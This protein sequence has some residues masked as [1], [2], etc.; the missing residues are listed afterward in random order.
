MLICLI[1]VGFVSVGSIMVGVPPVTISGIV[2]GVLVELLA[3]VD[4]IPNSA[5]HLVALGCLL[6]VLFGRGEI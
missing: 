6:I 1:V 3:Y 2:L 5:G 4:F